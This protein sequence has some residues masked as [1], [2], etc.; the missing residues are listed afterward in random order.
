MKSSL[1]ADKFIFYLAHLKLQKDNLPGI[2]QNQNI[3]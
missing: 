2:S 3:K 1:N